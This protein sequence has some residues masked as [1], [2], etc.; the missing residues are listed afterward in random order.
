MHTTQAVIILPVCDSCICSDYTGHEQLARFYNSAKR[1]N[2]LNI[3]LSFKNATRFDANMVSLFSALL[4]LLNKENDL[5]FTAG[6]QDVYPKLEALFQNGFLKIEGGI[7]Q[8]TDVH[9]TTL[10]YKQFSK[11][12]KKGFILIQA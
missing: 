3:H 4:F 10:P 12:D 8:I 11:E 9:S 2:H 1:Y 7:N 5:T 6:F